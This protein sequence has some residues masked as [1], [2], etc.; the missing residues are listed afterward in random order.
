MKK[1]SILV[2]LSVFIFAVGAMAHSPSALNPEFDLENHVFS[3]EVKHSVGGGSTNHFIEEVTIRHKGED[4]LVQLPGRQLSDAPMF[5][6]YMP[7]IEP[8]D[9]LKVEADCS[10]AGKMSTEFTVPEPDEEE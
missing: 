3:V 1:V 4:V 8:G 2:V 10:I 7:G 9:V 5:L 6:Y